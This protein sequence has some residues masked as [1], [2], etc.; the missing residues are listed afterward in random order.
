MTEP[1]GLISFSG[2]DALG[3]HGK[4]SFERFKRSS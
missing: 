1:V 4:D 3:W 2:Y